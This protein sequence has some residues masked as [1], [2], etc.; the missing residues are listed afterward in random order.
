[1]IWVQTCWHLRKERNRCKSIGQ[2]LM[3]AHALKQV[4]WYS[5]G[6]IVL[7]DLNKCLQH[8]RPSLRWISRVLDPTWTL[9][10]RLYRVLK[11]IHG[12]LTLS[13]YLE[14]VGEDGERCEELDDL[15][16]PCMSSGAEWQLKCIGKETAHWRMDLLKMEITKVPDSNTGTIRFFDL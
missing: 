10:T 11:T 5:S 6:L 15:R 9:Q 8:L 13:R 16:M 4:E 1:M 14:A 7:A 2:R 12:T 3:T